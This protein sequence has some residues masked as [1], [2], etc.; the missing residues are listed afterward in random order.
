MHDL[1]SLRHYICAQTDMINAV[2]VHGALGG[3]SVAFQ[4]PIAINRLTRSNLDLTRKI[5]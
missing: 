2:T 1:F 3:T 5:L 4:G